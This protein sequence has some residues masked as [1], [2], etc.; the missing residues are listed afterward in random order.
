[1]QFFNEAIEAD[2]LDPVEHSIRRVNANQLQLR[3]LID[4]ITA[5]IKKATKAKNR[6]KTT[7]E[8]NLFHSLVDQQITGMNS[9]IG[10]YEGLLKTGE[11]ALKIL[12]DYSDEPVDDSESSRLQE[13][14]RQAL[15]QAMANSFSGSFRTF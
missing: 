1:M 8:N 10:Q 12:A 7:S 9:M 14:N 13:L 4:E 2:V 11:A 15:L 5:K 3:R 6:V